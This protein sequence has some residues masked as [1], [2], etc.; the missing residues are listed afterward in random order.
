MAD[1]DCDDSCAAWRKLPCASSGS[2]S[3]PQRPV[4]TPHHRQVDVAF[5]RDRDA[6]DQHHGDRVHE[7]PAILEEAGDCAENVHLET[8]LLLSKTPAP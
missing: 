1:S 6:E 2:I 4:A 8:P 3:L 7:V 5:D